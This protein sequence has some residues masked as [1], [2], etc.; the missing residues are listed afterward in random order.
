MGKALPVKADGT[1][2]GTT[3]V[4]QN[5]ARILGPAVTKDPSL[6]YATKSVDVKPGDSNSFDLDFP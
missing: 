2:E 3:L 4:G 5:A 6:G 1:F